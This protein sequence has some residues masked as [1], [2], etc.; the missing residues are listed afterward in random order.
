[1]KFFKCN[2]CG[3]VMASLNEKCEGVTCC[4]EDV[5]ILKAGEVDAAVEKHVPFYEIDDNRLKV[6]VGETIHP[7]EEDHYIEFIAYEHGNMFEMAR[8]EPGMEP[9]A[10]FEYK[11]SG[12]LYE[13]CNKH[14]LWKK[15]VK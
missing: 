6:T 8:L 3:H 12:T 5:R 14:G 11:G 2:K 4:G 7:M 15:E 1:M 13:Y 9:K 10:V